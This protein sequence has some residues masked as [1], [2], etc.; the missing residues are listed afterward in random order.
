MTLPGLSTS[1]NS[2]G[3]AT[4]N[5]KTK[6]NH[7]F[8][9]SDV[10]WQAK[11]GWI[12]VPGL[13]SSQKANLW[14]LPAVSCQ[15]SSQWKTVN[16]RTQVQPPA[17]DQDGK[18]SCSEDLRGQVCPKRQKHRSWQGLLKYFDLEQDRNLNSQ[19]LPCLQGNQNH[20][21]LLGSA[22]Q[23][24]SNHTSIFSTNYFIFFWEIK[25]IQCVI[26][27]CQRTNNTYF[28][29]IVA[30]HCLPIGRRWTC[31]CQANADRSEEQ[32]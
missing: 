28:L 2:M 27:N 22:R 25:D 17:W 29:F 21:W 18:E 10:L 15:G 6:E 20:I 12:R 7:G 9:L 30:I 16:F 1:P 32:V 5:M 19:L 4:T 24:Q 13:V 11:A 31:I 14:L 3:T 23:W 8:I 26:R